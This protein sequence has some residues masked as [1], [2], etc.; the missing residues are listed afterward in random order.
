M[1]PHN[2]NFVTLFYDNKSI[3]FTAHTFGKYDIED[4]IIVTYIAFSPY[5]KT[6][7]C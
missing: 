5:F 4:D 7:E 6:Q 1:L 2:T 3:K